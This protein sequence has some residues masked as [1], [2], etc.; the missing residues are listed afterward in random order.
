MPSR[1]M[2]KVGEGREKAFRGLFGSRGLAEDMSVREEWVAEE[3]VV[4]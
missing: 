2:K 1:R 3:N 4:Q